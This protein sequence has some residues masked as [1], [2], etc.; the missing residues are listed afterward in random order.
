MR[1]EMRERERENQKRLHPEGMNI[2]SVYRVDIYPLCFFVE[3]TRCWG[4]RLVVK[5]L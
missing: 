1:E 4:F 3:K 2:M 5:R